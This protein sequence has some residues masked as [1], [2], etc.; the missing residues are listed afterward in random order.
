MRKYN[1]I[2]QPVTLVHGNELT[3]LL[4]TS[5]HF[6]KLQG[7]NNN[8]CE[9]KPKIIKHATTHKIPNKNNNDK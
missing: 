8:K 2:I 1:K 3:R 4:Y 7:G 6:H 5:Q 9:T